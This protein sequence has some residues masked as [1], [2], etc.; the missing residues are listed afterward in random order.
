MV[1][2]LSA[3]LASV[4]GTAFVAIIVWG[5][6][7]SAQQP[8]SVWDGVYT[9]AQATRIAPFYSQKCS[10]CHDEEMTGKDGPPIIGITFNNH[11]NNKSLDL[12]FEKIRTGMPEDEKGTL[13][14]QQAADLVALILQAAEMPAGE[15][16]LKADAAALKDVKFLSVPPQQ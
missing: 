12:L 4:V 14:P 6:S 1:R 15:T 2:G 3:C 8:K 5:V 11:W 13:T 16:E 10:R 7:A 9:D